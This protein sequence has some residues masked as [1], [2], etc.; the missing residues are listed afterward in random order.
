MRLV[1]KLRRWCG[2]NGN[3]EESNLLTNNKGEIH[4]WLSGTAIVLIIII[5][6]GVF[7]SITDCICDTCL[8]GLCN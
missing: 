6:L 4:V 5:V 7:G 3:D 1:E 2:T 8:C